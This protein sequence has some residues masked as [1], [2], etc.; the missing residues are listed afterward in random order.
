MRRQALAVVISCAGLAIAP[1]ATGAAHSK[2]YSAFTL[3]EPARPGLT[4]TGR[5]SDLVA[6]SNARVV[7]ANAWKRR[8]ARGELLRFRTTQ[9]SS[10][11]YDL[12]YRVRSVVSPQTDAGRY[13]AGRLPSAS[14]RHLLDSGTRGRSAFRVVRQPGIGGRVRLDALWAGVLT[15][16]AD[17]VPPGQTA[18]TEITVSALSLRGDECHSGTW[19]QSLGPAIGDSLAVARTTLVFAKKV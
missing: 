13:V 9:N 17:V 19:R 6:I 11:R 15:R 18:W 10:C 14:S 7:V 16:R 8:A 4:V 2:G 12:S 1:S 3:K 5:L